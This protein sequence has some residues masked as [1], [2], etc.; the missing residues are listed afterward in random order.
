M[1]TTVY[2][3]LITMET[4]LPDLVTMVFSEQFEDPKGIG[5]SSIGDVFVVDGKDSDV[6]VYAPTK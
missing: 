5:I 4:I 1:V 6:H 2:R 3:Y